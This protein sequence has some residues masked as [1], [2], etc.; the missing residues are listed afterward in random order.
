MTLKQPSSPSSSSSDDDKARIAACHAIITAPEASHTTRR[1]RKRPRS[2]GDK[3][4]ADRNDPSQRPNHTSSR[5]P[6]SQEE[7]NNPIKERASRIFN[8]LMDKV[9]EENVDDDDD[10][11]GTYFVDANKTLQNET[12]ETLD[13]H[14][15]KVPAASLKSSLAVANFRLFADSTRGHIGASRQPASTHHNLSEDGSSDDSDEEALA[16][17]RSVAV[18]APPP[19]FRTYS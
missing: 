14:Q 16:R 4:S 13:D 11:E 18:S 2:D 10:D 15:K 7:H 19:P 9:F 1:S 17:A 8:K 6:P 12:N 3:T 5:R